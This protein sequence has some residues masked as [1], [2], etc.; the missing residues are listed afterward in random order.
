MRAFR[1]YVRY[2]YALDLIIFV[3]L[4]GLC[5]YFWKD[6]NVLQRLVWLNYLALFIHQAEEYG[7]PGGEP[8]I[9]NVVLRHSDL[10]DRFPLNQFSAMF[11]NTVWA[12]VAY[13][14]PFFFPNVAWLL[15][16]PLIMNIGQFMVHGVMTN[17]Q[18]RSIYNPGLGAV[19]FLHLPLTV[20]GFI[21]VIQNHLIVGIDWLWCILTLMV[22]MMSLS[23][24]TYIV[25]ATR[26]SRWPFAPEELQKFGLPEKAKRLGLDQPREEKGPLGLISRMQR[27]IHPND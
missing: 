21:Y 17:L 25:L 22:V 19:V 23:V 3:I 14:V 24:T 2:W 1:Y 6:I 10:P 5:A 9:M 8:A 26:K 7:W 20:Y 16:M 27:K 12:F 13:F 4:A 18:L 11:T 15:F